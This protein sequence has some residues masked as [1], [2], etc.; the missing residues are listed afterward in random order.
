MNRRLFSFPLLCCLLLVLPGVSGN[1]FA[2]TQEVITEAN[3]MAIL[4]SMDKA[5]KKGNVA[6]MIAP[7]A[8]DVKI[9]IAVS[10]VNSDKEEVVNLTKEEYATNTR[11]LM[12]RRFKYTVE[13][14]NVRVKIYNDNKT[15]MVTNDVY[16]T[17]TIA[18]VTVR[19][20]SSET[21]IFNIRNGKILITSSESR[22]RFY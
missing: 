7:L 11:Q 5:A 3:V 10:A 12:R 8:S 13:R 14:K 2:Q 1:S 19:A 6:G 20:V 17:M 4:T 15:A 16:E 9:K 18:Q 22:T 21:S